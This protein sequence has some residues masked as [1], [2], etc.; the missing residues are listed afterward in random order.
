M[1]LGSLEAVQV[2]EHHASS[3]VAG[4]DIAVIALNLLLF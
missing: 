3:I 1:M 2:R 4:T